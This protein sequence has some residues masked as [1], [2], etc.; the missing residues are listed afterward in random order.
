M[1]KLFERPPTNPIQMFDKSSQ[2]KGVDA[3][4][5]ARERKCSYLSHIIIMLKFI[6][7]NWIKIPFFI[8]VFTTSGLLSIGTFILAVYIFFSYWIATHNYYGMIFLIVSPYF[9][10][11]GT[12]IIFEYTSDLSMIILFGIFLFVCGCSNRVSLEILEMDN[13]FNRSIYSS[14]F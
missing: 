2:L 6:L 7:L 13:L 5:R 8:F 10:T 12:S 1:N 4:R 14:V 9:L 11:Y 3:V